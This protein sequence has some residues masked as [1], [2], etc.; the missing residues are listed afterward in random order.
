MQHCL[1]VVL[2]NIIEEQNHSCDHGLF[3]NDLITTLHEMYDDISHVILQ[4][5][6]DFFKA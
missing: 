1:N 3:V 5:H 4:S 6:R 2:V